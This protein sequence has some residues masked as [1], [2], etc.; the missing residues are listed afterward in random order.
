MFYSFISLLRFFYLFNFFCLFFL[1]PLNIVVT[2]ILKSLVVASA[3]PAICNSQ[4]LVSYFLSLCLSMLFLPYPIFY[5]H[6]V[7]NKQN[8]PD[9]QIIFTFHL[10]KLITFLTFSWLLNFRK[11]FRY[12]FIYDLDSP[13][14]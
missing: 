1:N 9:F 10:L 2:T 4:S 12:F 5:E 14:I 7:P 11:I 6:C 3:T 8:L 13:F